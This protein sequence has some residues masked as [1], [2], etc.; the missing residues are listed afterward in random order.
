MIQPPPSTLASPVPVPE[1]TMRP[2]TAPENP[3]L[4]Q[5][6]EAFEAVFL[7]EM[8]SHAG[9]G[10]TETGEGGFDGGAGEAAFSSLLT[11]EW[12]ARLSAEGGVGL[13]DAI[14]RSLVARQGYHE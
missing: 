8:L 9:M 11:R 5:A 3:A 2:P 7:T 10:A 13:S 4:R 14:Y 6:A 12:A 1:G